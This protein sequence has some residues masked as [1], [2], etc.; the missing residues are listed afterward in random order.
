MQG[1]FETVQRDW[2]NKWTEMFPEQI[3]VDSDVRKAFESFDVDGDGHISYS[4]LKE[5]L[6]ALGFTVSN[7]QTQAVLA[8]FDG[9]GNSELEVTEFQQLINYFRMLADAEDAAT[10]IARKAKERASKRAMAV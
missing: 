7:Q 2:Q 10:E 8:K 4:E 5:A 9:D 1:W 6:T 3:R